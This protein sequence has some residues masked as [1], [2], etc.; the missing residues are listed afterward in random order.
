MFD[1]LGTALVQA[2]GLFGVFGFFAYQTL[3]ADNK[4]KIQN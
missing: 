2:L 3:L 4:P 1:N